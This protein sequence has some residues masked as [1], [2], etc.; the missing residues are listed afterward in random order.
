MKKKIVFYCDSMNNGGTEKATLDL[1]N[2]LPTDKYDITVI[3]LEPGG[4]YQKQLASHIKNKEILPFNPQMNFRYYWRFRRLY[5]KLP[6]RL[7]HKLIIGNKYDVEVG[8]G[9][10]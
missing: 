8:S 10:S 4:K 6:L 2:N 5:E 9:Y 1:V 3:Q 7:V